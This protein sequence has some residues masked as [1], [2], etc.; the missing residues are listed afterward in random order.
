MYGQKQIITPNGQPEKKNSLSDL[1]DVLIHFASFFC[2]WFLIRIIFDDI[3]FDAINVP[4]GFGICGVYLAFL[5]FTAIYLKTKQNKI[6][7]KAIFPFI[8]CVVCALSFAVYGYSLS[9]AIIP[10]M[11]YLSGLFCMSM[12]NTKGIECNS[13]ID[14]FIQIKAMLFVPISKL[15]TPVIS[16][17]RSI[18]FF[19]NK[20]HLGIILGFVCGV[21]VF[22]IVS[23]LLIEADAAFSG[24]MEGVVNKLEKI[25]SDYEGDLLAE[26]VLLIPVI[27]FYLYVTATVFGFRHGIIKE[28]IEKEDTEEKAKRR[29][30]ISVPVLTGFYGTVAICYVIY[31]LSQ[32]SYLFGAFSGNV[33]EIAGTV[34]EYARRGFFEMSTVA[35]IN[36][37]LIAFGALYL[38]RDENGSMPKIYKIFSAF[39]C[40]FT[41]ILIITAM[42]KM[43][44]YISKN[45]LT[46]KRIVVSCADIVLFVAFLSVLIRLFAKNFPYMKIIMGTFLVMTT[47]YFAVSPEYVISSYNTNAY[48]SGKHKELDVSYIMYDLSG[49]Y[50]PMVYLDKVAQS[51]TKASDEAKA[52]VYK[53]YNWYAISTDSVTDKLCSEYIEKNKQRIESYKDEYDSY[54]IYGYEAAYYDGVTNVSL[55]IYADTKILIDYIYF[56]NDFT[57][58]YADEYWRR[59][60]DYEFIGYDDSGIKEHFSLP[61]WIYYTNKKVFT[62]VTVIDRNGVEYECKIVDDHSDSGKYTLTGDK[63][64]GLVLREME[65]E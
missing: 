35:V 20:K 6:S 62:G 33:S 64:N 50:Y 12:T 54:E 14:I 43:G 49:H 59:D 22:L 10:F 60:Y 58:E 25:F 61:Y 34:S 42:S 15:F 17:F 19:K 2:V 57:S 5:I 47:A 38:K 8:L 56:E 32:M 44:L 9:F 51:D 52:L 16:V 40:M 37:C 7:L 24:V 53:I 23:A 28:K 39:F 11:F 48:L 31:L 55:E 36:L 29:Q 41:L 63:E 45:G 1:W 18:R 30:F 21:P 4:Y 27:P 46:V 26:L 65:T 13:F 3:F